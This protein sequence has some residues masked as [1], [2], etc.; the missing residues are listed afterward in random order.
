MVCVKKAITVTD[1]PNHR[2]SPTD[3]IGADQQ[4]AGN[5]GVLLIDVENII[6]NKAKPS[7]LTARLDALIRHTEPG[8]P[9]AGGGTSALGLGI[10]G[11]EVSSPLGDRG[12]RWGRALSWSQSGHDLTQSRI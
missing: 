1:A 7:R 11:L 2:V 3:R 10:A 12:H 9:L 8:E 6:G 5:G 4:H